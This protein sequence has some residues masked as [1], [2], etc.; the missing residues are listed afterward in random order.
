MADKIAR[1]DLDI[2][3]DGYISWVGRSSIEATMT[4]KQKYSETDLREILTAKFVMVSQ[5]P[6]TR[7][8][9]RNVPLLVE[10]EEEKENFYQ[11]EQ[12]KNLRIAREKNSLLKTVPTEEERNILHEI[13]LK[14]INEELVFAFIIMNLFMISE[15]ILSNVIFLQVMSGCRTQS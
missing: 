14:T 5:D 2:I 3:M 8:S 7:K 12:A 1:S 9:V 6:T 11:G 13:F 15:A 10:T 4:L